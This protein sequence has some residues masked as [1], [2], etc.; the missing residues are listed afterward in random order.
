MLSKISQ[1]FFLSHIKI[2]PAAKGF[3][4]NYLGGLSEHTIKVTQSCI[5]LGQL[6]NLDLNLLIT[7]ALLHDIGKI[8]EYKLDSGE[9]TRTESG[10]LLYHIQL[11]I[12]FLSHFITDNN[13]E[14]TSLEK[15]KLYHLI[16][17]HHGK[18]EFGSSVEPKFFEAHVLSQCDMIDFQYGHQELL[19]KEKANG[20]DFIFDK[21]N[22]DWL[23]TK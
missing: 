2:C 5:A 4:H 8:I 7:G 21:L 15:N 19:L 22:G 10:I 3:H 13:I 1:S 20:S 16:I 23:Y 12:M 11:G 18:K 14:L 9:I 6:Y 17:S